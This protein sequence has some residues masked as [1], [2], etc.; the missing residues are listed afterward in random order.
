[1]RMTRRAVNI[2]FVIVTIAILTAIV[3]TS[4][5]QDEPRLETLQIDLWSE[6]DRP[7]MLIVF[8]GTLPADVPLPATVTLR[9]PARVGEPH[10]VAYHDGSGNLFKASYSSTL[11]QDWLLV[12]VETPTPNFQLEYYDS[13]MREG[14]ER[15][16]T[17]QWPGDHVVDELSFAFLPPPGATEIQTEPA[18]SPFQQDTGGT[19]YGATLESVTMGEQPQVTISYRGGAAGTGEPLSV[20]TDG[21]SDSIPLIAS[22]AGIAVGALALVIG[23]VVW[24]TRR[25]RSQP[26]EAPEHQRRRAKRTRRSS[27]TGTTQKKSSPAGYCP[28]CGRPLQT[29][30]RFCGRCGTP[31]QAVKE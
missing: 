11:A 4:V 16:Y 23:G 24:Y 19:V 30:D 26:T 8:R 17:F 12:S 3:T 7:E 25:P 31:V 13:L 22:A 6:F 27:K 2:I 15:S 29:T 21:N 1:M 18:L 10:A 28:H 9:V 5:A 14:D 20:A